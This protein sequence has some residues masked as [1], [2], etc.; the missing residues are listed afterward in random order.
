MVESLNQCLQELKESAE[1]IDSLH[2]KPPGIFHNSLVYLTPPNNDTPNDENTPSVPFVRII[3]DLS[4]T[5][6]TSLFKFDE[7]L[8]IPVRKDG[9][10][11]ILDYLKNRE[12]NLRRSKNQRIDDDSPI[13]HV[14]RDIYLRAHNKT[15]PSN[16]R[17]ANA[18]QHNNNSKQNDMFESSLL[19]DLYDK[20]KD[21]EQLVNL[22]KALQ[23]GSVNLD[24][25]RNERR[26]TL[27]VED[28]DI[29][30]LLF[31]LKELINE[32]PVDENFAKYDA[33]LEE[34]L[35]LST[36]IEQLEQDIESQKQPS[37]I[38]SIEDL[39]E[40]ERREIEKI[41]QEL[42]NK[43]QQQQQSEINQNDYQESS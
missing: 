18:Y 42:E 14:P 1:S 5:E 7:K 21:N 34:Y 24:G 23:S 30:L 6:E 31:V 20:Y 39:I 19:Y 25:N 35:Q 40:N 26:K 4:P 8:R 22:L 16:K 33:L 3:R 43:E 38:N 36:Q 28:F 10:K 13:I 11:G 15:L 9:E 41:K 29:K 2:F 37:N 27:F 17:S 12:A 32:I